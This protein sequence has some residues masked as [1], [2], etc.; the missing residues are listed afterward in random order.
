MIE[1][2]AEQRQVNIRQGVLLKNEEQARRNRE[3][4]R[5]L[6]LLTINLISSP[7]AGKTSLLE[8][9]LE[10]LGDCL[11]SAVI[12]GDLG[13]DNDSQ[14]LRK[15]GTDVVRI[16]PANICHLEASMIDRASRELDLSG[17]RLL[18]I[19]N[20]G[21][22]VCPASYDLGEHLRVVLLAVTEGEDKPLKYPRIYKS[23]DVVLITKIDLVDTI[24]YDLQLARN[25]I[26]EIAPQ[27][28][29]F[30]LTSHLGAG[31]IDWY[32]YL[33]RQAGN[34]FRSN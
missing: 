14:R 28:E 24:G 21:N 8:R 31:L 26:R 7:G 10:D 25:N 18:F 30:E 20:V 32:G 11:P 33:L 29:V 1:S 15:P 13:A 3:R 19:E 16:V 12:V 22:L 27:A 4:F 34:D 23:A 17:C 5:R 6:G 9:T 2:S